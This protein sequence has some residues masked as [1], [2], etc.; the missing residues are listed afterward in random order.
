MGRREEK[1][2]TSAGA[3]EFLGFILL[4]LGH[5]ATDSSDLSALPT[6]LPGLLGLCL[7]FVTGAV[8]SSGG[9]PSAW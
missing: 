4:P 8:F 6:P 7:P 5:E 9:L 3:Y 1:G 2:A